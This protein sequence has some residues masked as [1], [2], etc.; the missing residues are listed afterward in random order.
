M[1][2]QL[3]FSA[4]NPQAALTYLIRQIL[5]E[6]PGLS[7]R[8]V[9]RRVRQQGF[10]GGNERL[11]DLAQ[12]ARERVQQ[13]LGG[14]LH[15]SVTDFTIILDLP[16]L[17]PD[18]RRRLLRSAGART[19]KVSRRGPAVQ[20]GLP[21][22]VAIDWESHY[23]IEFF[24]YGQPER[25]ESGTLTGQIVQPLERYDR[26]LITA[27]IEQQIIGRIT[28]SYT[29]GT[30]SYVEGLDWRIRRLDVNIRNLE[31]R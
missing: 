2:Q 1:V 22:F 30:E 4:S 9:V 11:R 23:S 7:T 28:Q 19:R 24:L 17:T 25:I 14:Q 21:E 15:E 5:T 3:I 29:G 26:E 20:L 12:I 27:R 31:L 13:E 6:N 10:R 16:S 18:R 8:A